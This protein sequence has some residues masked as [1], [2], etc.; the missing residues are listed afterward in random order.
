MRSIPYCVKTPLVRGS[1][2]CGL[3][4]DK[5]N[6]VIPCGTRQS[7]ILPVCCQTDLCGTPRLLEA[8]P[9][10]RVRILH[11]SAGLNRVVSVRTS[12]RAHAVCGRYPLPCYEVNRQGFLTL[13]L[14]VCSDF[15][16]LLKSDYLTR[17]DYITKIILSK[18][19][20]ERFARESAPAGS[21]LGAAS[22]RLLGTPAF[23]APNCFAV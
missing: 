8:R 7:C 23:D 9:C 21:A 15:P 18:V 5:P 16:L 6:S 19:A 11:V 13:F 2:I 17:F 1:Y 10:T 4:V 14:R 20:A 12:H 3:R 22:S